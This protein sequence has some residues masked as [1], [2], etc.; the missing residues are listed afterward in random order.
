MTFAE[1]STVQTQPAAT[2]SISDVCFATAASA[3][4]CGASSAGQGATLC[5]DLSDRALQERTTTRRDIR[6]LLAH[7]DESAA[8]TYGGR[9]TDMPLCVM[10]LACMSS[11]VTR[12]TCIPS[13][14]PPGALHA[15]HRHL[16]H[17]VQGAWHWH[18]VS[19]P[20][21]VCRHLCV[22]EDQ[23]CAHNSRS[24]LK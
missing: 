11:S 5:H 20:M 23:M 14:N 9:V 3:D 4:H 6:L 18:A 17:G 1:W 8:G 10:C 21:C 19:A 12:P 13:A 7:Q 2:D 16:W 15:V 22:L 24:D